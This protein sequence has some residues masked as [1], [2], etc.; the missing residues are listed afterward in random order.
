MTE[1]KN[2]RY[3]RR[4]TNDAAPY[5]YL[6]DTT[7]GLPYLAR[8]ES[9]GFVNFMDNAKDRTVMDEENFLRLFDITSLEALDADT[10]TVSMDMF[11]LAM[12][13]LR[14]TNDTIDD[15]RDTIDRIED[16]VSRIEYNAE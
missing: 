15:L 10:L 4:N 9:S 6:Q 2:N 12:R 5:L 3:Y 7:P 1:F 16:R 11:K 14:V 8:S 13:D